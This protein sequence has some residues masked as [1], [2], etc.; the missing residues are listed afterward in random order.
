MRPADAAGRT[1]P[2]LPPAAY[3]V[4]V[5]GPAAAA[6]FGVDQPA[7][8]AGLVAAIAEEHAFEVVAKDAVTLTP[9]R[10][11]RA[12]VL[13]PIEQGEADDRLVATREHSPL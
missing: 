10:F 12:H 11:G 2:I 5:A 8:P 6:R 13:D 4:A 7:R 1:R 3:E 9:R